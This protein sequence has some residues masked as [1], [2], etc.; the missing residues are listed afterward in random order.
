MKHQATGRD[1][2]SDDEE[3]DANKWTPQT[4]NLFKDFE[5]IHLKEMK[6][7]AIDIWDTKDAMLSA[8]DG[9]SQEYAHKAFSKFIF[10][11]LEPELQKT[12]QTA[13][14][15]AHLWNDGPYVWATLVHHFFPSPTALK[16]M[17]LHKMKS[18]TLTKHNN[19]LKAYCATLLDM[20]A[21]VDM[22]AHTEELISAFLTQTNTHPS[23][24][25]RTHFNQIGIK[26]FLKHLE[27]SIKLRKIYFKLKEKAARFC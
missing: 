14:S 25:V 7:W 16:T 10:G 23:E 27:L 8:K 2:G 12:V 13:I 21:I 20:N 9:Q 1:V 11:S 6:E 22:T 4:I 19:D 17:L 5:Q 18:A 3:E 26:L 15:P 24:I